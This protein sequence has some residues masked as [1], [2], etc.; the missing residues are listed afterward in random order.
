MAGC[1]PGYFVWT[2]L[3]TPVVLLPGSTNTIFSQE[4]KGGD[5]WHDWAPVT[6]NEVGS[7][8]GL[9]YN[10]SDG[11]SATYY[12]AAGY[13]Y[14]T[15]D[16]LYSASLGVPPTVSIMSPAPNATV[17]G[18]IAVTASAQAAPGKTIAGLN[19]YIDYATQPFTSPLDTTKFT[20]G[21]H[22][23]SASAVDSSGVYN[24]TPAQETI[25][26]QNLSPPISFVTN[27]FPGAIRNDVA[28][29]FG[30]Q[31]TTGSKPIQI[32]R[33]GRM[34]S[35]G[36]SRLHDITLFSKTGN[37]GGTF[38]QQWVT[39]SMAG[40][41]PGTYVYGYLPTPMI[42][43]PQTTCLITSHEF[44]GGDT[45]RDWGTVTTTSD[46][47]VNGLSYNLSSANFSAEGDQYNNSFVAAPG[48]TYGPVNFQYGGGSFP[49]GKVPAVTVT[50]PG[51]NGVSVSG[52]VTVSAAVTPGTAPVTQPIAWFV[53]NLYFTNPLNTATLA[54]GIHTLT[55]MATDTTGLTGFGTSTFYSYNG[56]ES[57][58]WTAAPTFNPRN[59]ATGWF[60][61]QFTTGSGHVYV[62]D[63]GRACI[64]SGQPSTHTLVLVAPSF[65]V[66]ALPTVTVNIPAVCTSP[67]VYGKLNQAFDM[68]PN[69]TFSVLSQETAGGA[70]WHDWGTNVPAPQAAG[71]GLRV[72]GLAWG[73]GVSLPSYPIV[74]NSEYPNSVAY[75][76]SISVS[77]GQNYS[78]VGI[79]LGYFAPTVR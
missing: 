71:D 56:N 7:A 18:S 67:F 49:S 51:P 32:T 50:S 27:Q 72:T 41:S 8:K 69:S 17:S 73:L 38:F 55:A 24:F 36:N 58:L 68:P 5:T 61:M 63:I 66:G 57:H 14:G 64:S 43:N 59:D 44:A 26:I 65:P 20:D 47:A 6:T 10:L 4:F 54:N 3:A 11:Y 48:Y 19:L 12:P 42:I 33:L 52:A 46:A 2:P 16:F 13:S 60:G 37:I 79:D 75:F 31:F 62:S 23:I 30:M 29:W 40:C 25:N 78:F 9:A 28:G 34:C 53:D 77:P 45:W 21:L 35:A 70:P 76:P 74:I 39:V 15:V 1:S 22:T